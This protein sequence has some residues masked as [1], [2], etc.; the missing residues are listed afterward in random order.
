MGKQGRG[1]Q[2]TSRDN[3]Q[4]ANIIDDLTR[5]VCTHLTLSLGSL[6]DHQQGSRASLSTGLMNRS[7]DLTMCSAESVLELGDWLFYIARLSNGSL[8]LRTRSGDLVQHLRASLSRFT[9]LAESRRIS[10]MFLAPLQSIELEFDPDYLD[11]LLGS[12][13][14]GIIQLT[15]AGATIMIRVVTSAQSEQRADVILKFDAPRQLNE[16]GHG[17]MQHLERAAAMPWRQPE[18]DIY[19]AVA[20]KLAILHNARLDVVTEGSDHSF[21]LALRFGE[22]SLTAYSSSCDCRDE[23]LDRDPVVPAQEECSEDRAFLDRM[24]TEIEANLDDESFNVAAL[25]TRMGM[26]RTHLYRRVRLLLGKTPSALLLET[27]L[28]RAA[29]R[30]SRGAGSI[31]QISD[32]V[33]FK[34]VSHFSQCFHQHFQ[35]PPSVFRGRVTGRARL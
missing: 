35:V 31:S 12:L 26:D 14:T 27:R 32:S 8:A 24:R 5:E 20:R 34:S 15:P 2:L 19:L 9:G 29:E 28:E 6:L 3:R 33:G 1:L 22:A 4:M 30:L 25:S 21:I 13:M 16:R 10:L 23:N 7:I 11:R 17:S 18:G